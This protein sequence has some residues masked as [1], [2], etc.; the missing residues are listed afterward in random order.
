[1]FLRL[2]IL[3][4][5]FGLIG[6]HESPVPKLPKPDVTKMSFDNSH[7]NDA[8]R[9]YQDSG[10]AISIILPVVVLR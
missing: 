5:Y 3:C 8:G 6:L 2:S 10:T 1:M 7:W 4:V 9:G